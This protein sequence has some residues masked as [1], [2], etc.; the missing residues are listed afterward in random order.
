MKV[1]VTAY[2]GLIIVEA[3]DPETPMQGWAP[4]G[5]GKI[6]S[7]I[8]DTAKNLGV[9]KEALDLLGQI[10]RSRDCIGEI[11][12]FGADDGTKVFGWMGPFLAVFAPNRVSGSRNYHVFAD[13]CK[14]I[15]NIPPEGI[16]KEIDEAFQQLAEGDE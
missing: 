1:K 9:S 8:C 10:R 13:S 5:P 7:I 15:P 14:L 11:D 2:R 12:W 16:R 6:G 4:N 3:Q